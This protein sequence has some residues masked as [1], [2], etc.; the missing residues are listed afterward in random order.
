MQI[1]IS[2][3]SQ[4]SGENTE[5]G[6]QPFFP[7]AI[8]RER[9]I[10]GIVMGVLSDGTPYLN[11]RGLASLCDV[12]NAHIGTISSQ[13]NDPAPK[14]RIQRIKAILTNV[15]NVPQM[16]TPK[17]RSATLVYLDNP[18]ENQRFKKRPAIY[19]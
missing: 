11:Q 9:E 1:K 12:M 18:A 16:P 7:L 13:W 3:L 15:G 14:P 10:D 5:K 17:R 4:K 6:N 8:E 19:I 2:S